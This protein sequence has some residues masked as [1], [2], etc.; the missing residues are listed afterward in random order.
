RDF[1]L[2]YART[3]VL[4]RNIL[5]AARRPAHLHGD[6]TALRGELHGIGQQVEDDLA[7]GLLVRPYLR[8]RGL[9]LLVDDDALRTGPQLH[10]ADAIFRDVEQRERFLVE[11]IAAC[12]DTREVEDLVDQVE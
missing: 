2:G 4:D 7:D 10:H 11:F 5:P 12:L 9:E 3:I 1:L 8:Q 6:L